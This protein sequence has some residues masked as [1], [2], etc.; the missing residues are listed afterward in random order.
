LPPFFTDD[1]VKRL[2]RAHPD[3]L[4][5]ASVV[6]LLK[7]RG[8]DIAEATFRKY[9]QLGLLP[10]SRRV[11]RKGKH[12]GSHGLYPV[13]SAVRLAEIRLLMDSGLTLEEIQRSVTHFFEVDDLRRS[14]HEVVAR[15][16]IELATRGDEKGSAGRRLQ[17]LHSQADALAHALESAARDICQVKLADHR[18]E[19]PAAVAQAAV[20]AMRGRRPAPVA[21]AGRVGRQRAGVAGDKRSGEHR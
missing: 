5:A 11:G 10:R 18:A 4:S 12:R 19:D 3:G 17:S 6:E 9:V 8:I 1:E 15:L 21:A 16:E 7:R 14:A 20:A 2:E 13:A